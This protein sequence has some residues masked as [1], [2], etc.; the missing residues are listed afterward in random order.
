M[1]SK[2]DLLQ[3]EVDLQRAAV[4][5]LKKELLEKDDAYAELKKQLELK[6]NE[7]AT[8]ERVL[9][10]RVAS[11]EAEV[12]KL[13]GSAHTPANLVQGRVP[14]VIAGFPMSELAA[15]AWAVAAK[16]SRLPAQVDTLIGQL[17]R[18]EAKIGAGDTAARCFETRTCLACRCRARARL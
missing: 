7:F 5:D 15:G 9:Q 2:A 10:K 4:A 14:R 17:V 8:M 3:Q 16:V 13:K 11:L 12:A 18:G 6:E 1:P